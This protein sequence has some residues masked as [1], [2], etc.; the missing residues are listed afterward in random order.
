VQA[1]SGT[2]S[3]RISEG[4]WRSSSQPTLFISVSF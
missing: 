1:K 2:V 4:P 3:Y